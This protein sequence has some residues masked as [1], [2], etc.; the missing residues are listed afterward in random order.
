MPSS[1]TRPSRASQPRRSDFSFRFLPAY[2]DDDGE[3]PQPFSSIAESALYLQDLFDF[4]NLEPEIVS[5]PNPIAFPKPV[6][7]G[8]VFENVS[9]HYPNREDW[10]LRDGFLSTRSREKLA[11][12]GENGAGKTTL[13]KLLTRLYDPSEGRILLDREGPA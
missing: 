6:R 2:E 10:V 11:L 3:C 5:K 9:F 4:F 7:E 13:V 12:V 1:S 8:F